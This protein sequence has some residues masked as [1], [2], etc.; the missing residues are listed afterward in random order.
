MSWLLLN[1]LRIV[2]GG[3]WK[4]AFSCLS[5]C[6]PVFLSVY[7]ALQLSIC[8]PRYLSV[9]LS[10]RL[11][12]W[13]SVCLTVCPSVCLPVC[14]SD[15]L[16]VWLTVCLTVCLSIWLSVCLCMS[17]CSSV[18][19]LHVCFVIAFFVSKISPF[20]LMFAVAM[21]ENELVDKICQHFLRIL[22]QTEQEHDQ[23]LPLLLSI[24]QMFLAHC[25]KN[26]SLSIMIHVSIV[27]KAK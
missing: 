3:K 20:A 12:G 9:C 5:A 6:P 17:V 18:C 13:L 11:S 2:Q 15:C 25:E 14:L 19:F 24:L 21:L 1:C 7:L 4:C 16:S 22:R 27:W 26:V 10:V 8:L 23:E